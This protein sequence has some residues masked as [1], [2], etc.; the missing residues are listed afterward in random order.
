VA[1]LRVGI[2][3]LGG[4]GAIHLEAYR[5][6]RAVEVVAA[7]EIDPARLEA[8][9]ARHDFKAYADYKEMLT[10]ESIDLVVVATPVSTHEA[11]TI[12]PPTASA[13]R[14]ATSRLGAASTKATTITIVR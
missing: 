10:G 1:K 6:S 9:Q 5:A 3:G 11:V 12:D 4:V 8:A 14:V 7:A 2:V 13:A